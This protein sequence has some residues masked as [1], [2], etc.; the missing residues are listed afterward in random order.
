MYRSGGS[1][2]LW[3]AAGLSP[4]L[5]L[6][7]AAVVVSAGAGTLRSEPSDPEHS[8]PPSPEERTTPLGIER[9]KAATITWIGFETPT[10]HAARQAE[11]EQPALTL[12]APAQPP[13]PPHPPTP[14][15]QATERPPIESERPTTEV[16]ER[17]PAE[18]PVESAT[19]EEVATAEP[20]P[21]PVPEP[22]D[23]PTPDPLAVPVPEASEAGLMPVIE[24]LL[25]RFV[26]APPPAQREA[27]EAAE[28][29]PPPAQESAQ[30]T[31]T[32]PAP[33][34]PPPPPPPGLSEKNA[35]PSLKAADAVSLTKPVIVRPGR[36]AAAEGLEIQTRHLRLSLYTQVITESTRAR[37]VATFNR[38]GRVTKV[39]WVK[40]TGNKDVDEPIL[41]CVFSWRAKGRALEDIPAGDPKAGVA[42]P[43][44]IIVR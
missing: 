9:S 12:D 6:L 25:A 28:Q 14:Q 29:T 36:P 1:R 33:S 43:F 21:D 39:E 15:A 10:E 22:A 19:P 13:Q 20:V 31:P 3:L 24:A 37:V 35:E 23:E 38:E 18:E 8:E 7:G 5:H 2:R 30:A 11:T 4:L 41:D 32:A 40:R 34:S 17:E 44:E 42:I 26:V 16:V 27:E